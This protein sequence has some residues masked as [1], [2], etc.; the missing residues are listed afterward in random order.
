MLL[1]L[2]ARGGAQYAVMMG[3]REYL[4]NKIAMMGNL[5]PSENFL[6]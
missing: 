6:L 3:K 4:P 5:L 2:V 1:R